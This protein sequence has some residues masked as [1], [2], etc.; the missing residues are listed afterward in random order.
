MPDINGEQLVDVMGLNP[1]VVDTGSTF[2]DK[3]ISAGD[4]Q[5]CV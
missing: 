5:E 2:V 4:V 1:Q 3:H